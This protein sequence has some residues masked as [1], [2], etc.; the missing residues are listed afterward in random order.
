[1]RFSCMR[2]RFRLNEILIMF[3]LR[4]IDKARHRNAG[5]MG[6]IS[7]KNTH[8]GKKLEQIILWNIATPL[9]ARPTING[10][11]LVS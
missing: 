3:P 10:A 2:K 7:G 9:E 8:Q 11:S 1:M 5:K 6:E 4:M